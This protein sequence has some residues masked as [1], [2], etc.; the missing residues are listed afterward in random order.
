MKI[1]PMTREHVVEVAGEAPKQTL[2]GLA[3]LND[4]GQA[5]GVA[6]GYQWQG[7]HL[8]FIHAKDELRE[9]PFTLGRLCKQLSKIPHRVVYALC[10]EEIAGSKKLLEHYGFVDRGDGYYMLEG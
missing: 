2:R 6:G 3:V 8:A 10:D 5:I 1:V 7:V 4:E 9:H